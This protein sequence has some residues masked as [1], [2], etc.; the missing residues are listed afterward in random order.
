MGL[1][2]RWPPPLAADVRGQVAASR[3][4]RSGGAMPRSDGDAPNLDAGRGAA[5]S[6][7]ALLLRLRGRPRLLGFHVGALAAEADARVLEVPAAHGAAHVGHNGA[8][9]CDWPCMWGVAD[10]QGA[11]TATASP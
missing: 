7:A 8:N 6:A 5:A 11:K 4:T 9:D 1:I 3:V 10:G 2:E